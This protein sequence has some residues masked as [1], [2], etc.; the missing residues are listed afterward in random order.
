LTPLEDDA[1]GTEIRHSATP[2]GLKLWSAGLDGID[3]GG[4]GKWGGTDD[5]GHDDQTLEVPR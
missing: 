1:F 3:T 5:A 2:G 4:K